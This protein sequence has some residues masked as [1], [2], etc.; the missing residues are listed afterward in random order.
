MRV[1]NRVFALTLV[2]S[3]A[4]AQD[5][6]RPPVPQIV[7]NGSGEVRVAPDR[8][9]I[10]IGVQSRAATAAEAAAANSRRQRAVIDAIKARGIPAEQIGTM[11]FNVIP[12]TRYDREGQQAPRTTSYLVSNVVTV[13]VRRI[14][15][16]GPVIDAALAAGAN[17]I[18]SLSFGITGAD[19]ARRVALS[20]AVSKARADAEIMARAAGGSL[21]S[22]IEL[23]AME[24][25][26]PSPR[27][28]SMESMKVSNAEVPIEAGQET[29][30]AT[31]MAR[32]Q[33]IQGAP[34]R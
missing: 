22:L 19:S 14:D 18:N 17:Q 3:A 26:V 13:D 11:G 16:V 34:P 8:A 31:V 21:G 25:Y 12:E 32:W 7:V 27:A 2:A 6:S 33:F 24:A 15:Q 10:Q 5:P 9:S 4:V 20:N 1:L 29:I 28:V 23:H 30:R